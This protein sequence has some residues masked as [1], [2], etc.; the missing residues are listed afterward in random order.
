M[1]G[2]AHAYLEKADPHGWARA[3]FDKTPKCDLLMNNISECFNSYIILACDKPIIVMLEMIRKKLMRRY[4]M[5]R[6]GIR[7][8]VGNWC[9]KILEK[10]EQC[11][12]KAGDC[13][14][15][16]AGEGLFEVVY[17]NKQF[18]VDLTHK[19]CGCRQWDMTSIPCPHAIAAIFYNSS[20]PEDYLHEYYSVEMYKRAYDLMIFPIPSEEQWVRTNQDVVDPPFVKAA[21]GR[22]KKLRSRGPDEPRNSYR[23][24]KGG[25]TMR[26]LHCRQVGHNARTCSRRIRVSNASR[27]GRSQSRSVA[28]HL[29]SNDVSV[30]TNM[31]FIPICYMCCIAFHYFFC[32]CLADVLPTNW[33]T[34]HTIT[35]TYTRGK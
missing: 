17:R 31:H 11:G 8:Y 2:L 18:V 24:R 5:K 3:F 28:T 16:Y 32:N 15:T 13:I 20:N 12:K 6:E 14:A 30:Y 19:T 23:I 25:V 27:S 34:I 35:N 4:Q 26:C 1:S 22:P 29:N 33:I 9:P 7:K 21:L 10:L